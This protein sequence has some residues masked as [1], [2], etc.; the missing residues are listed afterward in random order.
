[1]FFKSTDEK[2]I[3]HSLFFGYRSEM[4][5]ELTN[6]Y[7]TAGV[8]HILSVSGLHVGIV[9]LFLMFITKLLQRKFLL[10]LIRV[11]IIILAIWFYGLIAGFSPPVVRSCCMFTLLG[12]TQILQRELF[13]YNS[14]FLSAFIILLF[15]PFQL[16]DIGFQLSYSAMLGIFTFYRPITKAMNAQGY[17]SKKIIELIAV[18]LAAQLGTL[19]LTLYYF[20]SFPSYFLLS[21]LIIVPFA[22]IIMYSGIVFL[23]L[24]PFPVLAEYSAQFLA[25]LIEWLNKM[26]MLIEQLPYASLKNIYL[27]RTETVIL[28]LIILSLAYLINYRNLR[29]LPLLLILIIIFQISSIVKI[30]R[31]YTANHIIFSQIN[32]TPL[33]TYIHQNQAY[34][35]MCDSSKYLDRNISNIMKDYYVN[36]INFHQLAI[37]HAGYPKNKHIIKIANHEF[38]IY[39]Q[40]TR[41]EKNEEL[42]MIS[43]PK[44]RV[45]MVNSERKKTAIRSKHGYNLIN[46]D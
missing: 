16:Y 3:F 36:K 1:S 2:S 44:Y 13:P 29:A 9:Y 19:P 10:Q 14:L 22:S 41:T 42:L 4:D 28:V 43:T 20:N 38:L 46:L 31:G 6:A 39:P 34:C 11:L 12:I 23:S 33:I 45:M 17:L 5:T 21:N 25:Q 7:A 32:K 27:N 37:P 18:S 15:D 24:T 40:K 35:I 26:V 8:I 30:F